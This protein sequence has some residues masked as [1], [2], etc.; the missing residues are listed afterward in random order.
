MVR[1]AHS[2]NPPFA[3]APASSPSREY[4]YTNAFGSAPPNADAG[5]SRAMSPDPLPEFSRASNLADT[6]P[7]ASRSNTGSSP[8][9]CFV[10]ALY[11]VRFDAGLT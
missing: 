5:T 8:A 4:R 9:S 2:S 6:S 3:V 11:R 1:T 7:P 10:V